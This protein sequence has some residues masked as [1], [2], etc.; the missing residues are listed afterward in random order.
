MSIS[1]LRAKFDLVRHE[2]RTG[3]RR[4][5]LTRARFFLLEPIGSLLVRS[6]YPKVE[7]GDGVVVHGRLE[8]IGPGRII[9]GDDCF[10]TNWNGVPNRIS[11]TAADAVV[12]LGKGVVLNGASIVATRSVTI[13]ER[14]L[15]GP[16][17]IMD[18]D[19]HPLDPLERM[20]N[21]AGSSRPVVLGE[22]TWVGR[23][24]IILKGVTLG[25][26]AVV[27]AGTVVRS[28]VGKGQIVVGNPQQ[29]VGDVHLRNDGEP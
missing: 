10:F 1:S 2:L 28:S 22:E 16:C 27:G 13:G 23:D 24:A 5:A 6:S 15:L 4:A 19:F 7:W 26:R 21:V 11:T 14:S 25:A 18:S 9:I 3:G 8:M 17:T 12:V 20:S 29:I